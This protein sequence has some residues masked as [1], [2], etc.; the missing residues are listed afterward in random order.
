M[1]G[2]KLRI[3]REQ[4]DVT[5]GTS[6]QSGAFV[7]PAM[8]KAHSSYFLSFVK[9]LRPKGDIFVHPSIH[10]LALMYLGGHTFWLYLR[11]LLGYYVPQQLAREWTNE[12]E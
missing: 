3:M 12:M 8:G 7:S 2:E 10:L 4:L 1:A 6:P 5:S 11:G 9:Y